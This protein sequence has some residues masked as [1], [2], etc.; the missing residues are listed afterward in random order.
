MASDLKTSKKKNGFLSRLFNKSEQSEEEI[1]QYYQK[2]LSKLRN[3]NYIIYAV[4]KIGEKINVYLLTEEGHV[5]TKDGLFSI[6]IKDH[7][8]TLVSM[9]HGYRIYMFDD[10]YVNT[11]AN[12]SEFIYTDSTIDSINKKIKVIKQA[13]PEQVSIYHTLIN[14]I[15]SNSYKISNSGKDK[16]IYSAFFSQLDDI[17][18]Y[19]KK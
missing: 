5:Y 18:G 10:R 3:K 13:V 17:K 7:F 16:E 6:F 12:G 2:A 1:H 19:S 11:Y 15:V 8:N 9:F 14:D 4:G